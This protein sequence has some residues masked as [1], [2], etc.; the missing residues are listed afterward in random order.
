MQ[1]LH[2]A[3]NPKGWGG[4]AKVPA[5]QKIVCHLSQSH[6]LATKDLDFIHKHPTRGYYS[7]FITNLLGISEM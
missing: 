2:L 5:G 3:F 1:P 7:H 6:A 4:G